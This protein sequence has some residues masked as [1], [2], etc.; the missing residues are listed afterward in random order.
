[1]I[2]K[3]TSPN[4]GNTILIIAKLMTKSTILSSYRHLEREDDIRQRKEIP[5]IDLIRA[6]EGD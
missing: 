4:T 6:L 3:A 2:G 5:K 1:M